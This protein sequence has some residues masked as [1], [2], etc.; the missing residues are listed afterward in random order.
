MPMI[1]LNTNVTVSERARLELAR[2]LGEAIALIPGKVEDSLM[3][4]ISGNNDMFFKGRDD[5]PM[6]YVRTD[7]YA[8]LPDEEYQ[9][10]GDAVMR[11]L[12]KVLAIPSGNVYLT[13]RQIPCWITRG[14]QYD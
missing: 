10:F 11:L 2:G 5:I 1:D 4:R 12:G 8:Q 7:L 3:L 13:I 14:E 9:P 6:A